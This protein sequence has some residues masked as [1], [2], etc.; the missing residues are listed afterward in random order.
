MLWESIET[1]RE[2]REVCPSFTDVWMK[3]SECPAEG[4]KRCAQ[5]YLNEVGFEICIRWEPGSGCVCNFFVC[6]CEGCGCT[7]DRRLRSPMHASKPKEGA[8]DDFDYYMIMSEYDRNVH[9]MVKHCGASASLLEAPDLRTVLE[10][11]ADS[12]LDGTLS[13]EEFNAAMFGYDSSMLCTRSGR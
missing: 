4:L 7:G 3:A 8:C 11:L 1:T 5:S 9:L 10:D 13:C 12:N 2:C 6:N